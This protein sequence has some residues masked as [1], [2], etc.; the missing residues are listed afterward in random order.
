MDV[1]QKNRKCIICGKPFTEKQ[2]KESTRKNRIRKYCSRKCMGKAYSELKKEIELKKCV[3]CNGI[4]TRKQ[5]M[6]NRATCS[7]KCKRKLLSQV[8]QTLQFEP[9]Y[10]LNC[11]K[12]LIREQIQGS[13]GHSAKYCS[14]KCSYEHRQKIGTVKGKNNPMYGKT[15]ILNSKF[16]S[17]PNICEHCGKEYLIKASRCNMT[18]YCSRLCQNKA[19]GIKHRGEGSPRY[20]RIK[21]QCSWCGKDLLII[22]SREGV[23]YFCDGKCYGNWRAENITGDKVYNWNNGS[24]FIPYGLNWTDSL[25][26]KIRDRDLHRCQF[27]GKTEK[28]NGRVLDV[29]H[30][31]SNP[32]N[33]DPINLIS[34]CKS[35]HIK[36]R[37]HRDQWK[38]IFKALLLSRNR[39]NSS[40]FYLQKSA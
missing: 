7:N 31:D 17:M 28:A 16:N 25:K 1:I 36:T 32:E 10:C 11:Q 2:L 19:Q 24:S 22:P 39:L 37:S 35:C 23:N 6:R 14:R 9:R 30:I 27:C 4:L 8:K 21:K 18:K 15:G 12:E 34:L 13:H 5:S 26:N 33:C 3:I 40:A 38:S 29:H 20:N